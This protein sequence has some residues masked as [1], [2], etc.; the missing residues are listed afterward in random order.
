MRVRYSFSSRHTGHA[1]DS[2]KN[3]KQRAKYPALLQKVLDQS[4]I[5]LQVLD[6]RFPEH[7]RNKEF[8]RE[9]VASGKKILYIINKS[10]LAP[11]PKDLP[12]PYVL[13]SSTKRRG[14]GKLR[15]KI[16]ILAK[17][18]EPGKEGKVIVGVVGYPNT[19]KS[20]LINVLIGKGSA[21]VGS[22]AGFTK[23]LQ[24]L[25][26]S[27]D[28]I[29]LD[30]PGVIPRTEYS[31]SDAKLHSINAMVGARSYSQVKD[32]EQTVHLLMDAFPG[33]FDKH[34][35][36]ESGNDSEELLEELGKRRHFFSQGGVVDIDK[37]AR[38]VIKEWQEGKIKHKLA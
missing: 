6:A 13:I 18:I 31:S 20:S 29:L 27:P 14:V 19:G 9:V 23:G 24:K 10:D 25:R 3:Q 11:K 5:I 2:P 28:I 15:E 32:P 21:G 1:R 8:E 33:V 26:L 38:F 17:D 30:S 35:K 12:E 34:Y 36:T 4:Q 22:D 7:T 16:K 37:T